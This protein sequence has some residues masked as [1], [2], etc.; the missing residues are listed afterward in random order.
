VEADA[1]QAA[2]KSALADAVDYIDSGIAP[3]RAKA[4][5]YYRGDPFGNEEE[6]RSQ[7]VMTVVRDKIQAMIPSLLR[8]FTSSEEMVQYA[9]RTPEKVEQA[10][11]ATDY[12]N[13]VIYNDNPGFAI[14]HSWLK[15]GLTRKVGI[16]KWR[17]AEEDSVTESSFTSLDDGQVAVIEGT[18]GVEVLAKT[19]TAE[20][21]PL[22]NVRIRRTVRAGRVVIE[23]VP[24]E[25][26][27]VAR[28]ARDLDTA[29]LVAHRSRPTISDLVA[30]G[31][32]R[33]EIEDNAGADSFYG[34]V[35]ETARNPFV[36]STFGNAAEESV[37]RRVD[38]TESYIRIDKDEDGIA[39]LR[40]VC[41]LGNAQYVLHDEVADEVPLA[42]FCPDPEPHMIFGQS[43]AD[44]VM[45]LQLITSNIVRNTLDSL[46]QSIHPRTAVVEG[47]VNLDDVMNNEVGGIIRQRAPG[48]VTPLTTPFVGQQALPILTFMDEL[49]SRRTGVSPASQGLDPDVLQ[50]TT[51]AAVTATVQ[52]A[53][54]RV[55][56]VA[57]FFAENG[58]KRLFKGLL[59]LICKHQDQPRTIRLRG[60]WVTVDPRAW[61]AT[62]DVQVNVA[63]GRGTDLDK[64]H[65]L[66]LILQKQ[67]LIIQTLGPDNPIVTVEEYRNT[68]AQITALMGFKDAARYFKPVSADQL[69][70]AMAQK[71]PPPDPNMLLVQIEQQKAQAKIAHDQL[72]LQ[73]DAAIAQMNDARERERNQMQAETERQ[74][75]TLQA[76][77]ERYKQHLDAMIAVAKIEAEYKTKLDVAALDSR[78]AVEEAHIKATADKDIAASA[79]RESA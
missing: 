18:E 4:T 75:M 28:D 5:A 2:I 77:V 6:G 21:L 40:R 50:S 66:G 63:L 16:V 51:K 23:C 14:L 39:E 49:A 26:F 64:I 61:D 56:L 78:V 7:I 38:Y 53:Q 57:R 15:D 52:G 47:Q 41:T 36:N 44:Q 10:E 58:L 33:E 8:I 20:G 68:L 46:A 74:R 30:M 70:A 69:K 31:Y 79:P 71:Q 37:M 59:K 32:D 43:V 11:Q 65:S 67:E 45:D 17:W 48:M 34:N 55:E 24:C 1:Y 29:S 35:E 27:L 9:P 76:E 60:K 25:E 19:P 3:D 54:E 13:H 42:V 62:L 12:I 72:K 73:Q 22:W